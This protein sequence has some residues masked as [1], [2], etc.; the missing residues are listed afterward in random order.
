MVKENKMVT[1][2]IEGKLY[3]PGKVR[4]DGETSGH[5]LM[6]LTALF[7]A[8]VCLGDKTGISA[9]TVTTTICL[10]TRNSSN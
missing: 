1:L 5:S 8:T 3:L 9:R 4:I 6:Y 7:E 2:G 10:Q